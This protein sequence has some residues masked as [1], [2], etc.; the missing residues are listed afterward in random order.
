[1]N[2][3]NA[4]EFAVEKGYINIV[5]YL[6]SNG[7]NIHKNIYI[8]GVA[9]YN[10]HFDVVKILVKNGINIHA[11]YGCALRNASEAGHLPI[12]KFLA[13]N[14]DKSIDKID[15]KK[16]KKMSLDMAAKNG[17]ID[18]VK[19]FVEEIGIE[20]DDSLILAADHGHYKIVKYL[21]QKGA[22][23]HASKDSAII[24]A[25]SNGHT[26]IVK[27]LTKKGIN[28]HAYNDCAIRWAALN[29]H[30]DIVDFLNQVVN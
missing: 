12:V 30:T 25:S 29:G 22:D 19:Y 28:I 15:D 16:I 24:F 26:K 7:A 18:I 23:V 6:I 21:V 4:F 8:I 3:E 1:M 14:T 11:G 27:F 2:L 20:S 10:G 13:E 17:N 9:A 5:E